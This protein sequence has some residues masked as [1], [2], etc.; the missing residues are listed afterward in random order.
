VPEHVQQE[1][2]EYW[3]EHEP[4]RPAIVDGDTTLNY[5]DWNTRANQLATTLSR[6]DL[7]SHSIGVRLHQSTAWFEINLALA[8]LRWEHVAVS[9]RLTPHEVRDVLVD[10]G[11]ALLF[12]DDEDQE[13]LSGGLRDTGIRVISTSGP[14]FAALFDVPP[15]RL[16]SAGPAVLV[17]YSSGTTGKPKGVRP[18]IPVDDQPRQ[19]LFAGTDTVAAPPS[20]ATAP[21]GAVVP[22]T[23]L[24]VPLHHGVGPKSAWTCHQRGGTLFLL[25]R[26]DPVRALE[27]IQ[28]ERIT[29][30]TTVPTMLQRIR[31]LPEEVLASYDVSSMRM[32]ATGSAP[33]SDSMKTWA[34]GYFGNCLY[35]GYGVSEVGMV[36]LM[37]PRW[38]RAKPG[39]C[40]RPRPGV[41]VR[42]LGEDG[43]DAPAGTAGEIYVKTPITIRNYVNQPPLGPDTLTEDGY[44]RTGDYGRL[45][46]D[47]FV[48]ITGRTKDMIIA[49]GV[50]I[51]P[52]EI[53]QALTDHPD[54]LDAAV[55]GIPEE[56]FGE[57]VM[58]FCEMR[59]EATATEADL[60][61]FVAPKLAAF[62][63]PRKI[64]MIAELPRN[65]MDKVLKNELRR[66]YWTG[67]QSSI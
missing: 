20:R 28:R 37:R 56:T 46:E 40:G 14:E 57:Q 27:V 16:H 60:L 15:R 19:R 59:P 8:K 63:R 18:N 34:D 38:R 52:A 33:S 29:H 62:K 3:A 13:P 66:P 42:I 47:G 45:D 4:D 61:D 35:E 55:V 1:S 67:R 41:S 21:V 11:A 58:A 50:N 31:A 54:V 22:R 7:G 2:P 26:F 30:W 25:D 53:E 43:A 24:A 51:F 65:H 39:S 12:A 6:L 49:G 36:T 44:F 9:W 10:S 17:M 64:A 23:L 48:Y 5:R 32:L